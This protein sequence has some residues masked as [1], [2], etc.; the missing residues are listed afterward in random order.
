[1]AVSI[2]ALTT[3]A[4]AKT[5]LDVTVATHDATIERMID[6]ASEAIER[7]CDREFVSRSQTEY[8][9]GS[10]TDRILLKHFPVTAVAELWIDNSSDFT[11]S[12]NQLAADEFFIDQEVGVGL[13][14]GRLF[15][16]GTRNIKIT[17]TAGFTTI[18]KD[19]E[20]ACIQYVE[21]LYDMW[22]D[23]RLGE[24]TKS[25]GDESITYVQ[26]VPTII[27]D[28][29]MPFKRMD[30]ALSNAMVDNG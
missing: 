7:F 18:P 15:G 2:Y 11:D 26:G 8:Q 28:A 16:R 9:Y 24:T 21:L 20:N 23:R 27:V 1:M 12:T 19:L 30:L 25:K 17:Y 14:P 6:T 3:L 29:L 4:T 10:R 13:K 5:H 22:S